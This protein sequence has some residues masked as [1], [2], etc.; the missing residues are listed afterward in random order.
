MRK[1]LVLVVLL[2]MASALAQTTLE[3]VRSRGSLICGV[4][5]AGL[6]GFT[7]INADGSYSGFDVDYCRAIAAAVLGDPQAVTFRGLSAQERFTA[8]QTGE[9]DVLIRNTT[10][11][12]TQLL[13]LTLLLQRSTTVKVLWPV[14]TRVL[15]KL[16]TWTAPRFAFSRVRPQSLT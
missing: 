14:Q 6:A 3:T 16:T 15:Q 8:L 12:S 10:W 2:G 4:N 13:V 5:A 11:T 1:L 9:I 7:N